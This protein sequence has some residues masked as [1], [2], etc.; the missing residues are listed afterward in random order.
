MPNTF[1]SGSHWQSQAAIPCYFFALQI[2]SETAD[3]CDDFSVTCDLFN[4][5][6]LP[7]FIHIVRLERTTYLDP[8]Y[9]SFIQIYLLNAYHVPGRNVVDNVNSKM[10]KHNPCTYQFMD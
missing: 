2:L 3:I 1:L 9:C 5:E 6:D 4:P 8:I 10:N 7:D